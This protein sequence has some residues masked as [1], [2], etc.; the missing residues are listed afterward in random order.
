M[1]EGTETGGTD[2][3]WLSLTD[4][5]H[6]NTLGKG[7]RFLTQELVCEEAAAHCSGR[8]CPQA[9]LLLKE[10]SFVPFSTLLQ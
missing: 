4:I 8:H 10:L 7:E 9:P 3:T 6:G 2:A 1:G 5:N